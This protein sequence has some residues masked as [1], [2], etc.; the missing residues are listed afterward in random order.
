MDKDIKLNEAF[1]FIR[2]GA[3]IKQM[4]GAGGYPITRIE[5]IANGYVDSSR[6]GYADIQELEK[7]EDYI[8]K[9]GD[10]LMSHINSEKH[11][12][13]SA[14]YVD[15][16]N[17]VIHGMNLLGLRCK[18]DILLPKYAFYYFNSEL[19][20]RQIPRITKKSVNQASFSVTDLRQL[21]IF[22]LSIN[23]QQ[24]IATILDK[25]QSL[26][27]KRKEQIEACD[28]LVKS[29]FYEMFGDP[30]K[31]DKH[32]PKIKLQELGEWKSGGT[33]SRSNNNYYNGNIPWLSSGEL[34]SIYTQESNE[35]ITEDAVTNSSAK[36][37][38][39]GSLLLGMYDTA[40]LK[41]TINLVECT[42]NQAIVFAKLNDAKVSTVFIYYCI[43]IGKEFY[44]SQQRGVRQKNLN[45]S[46]VKNMEVLFPPLSLQNKFAAQVEKIEHQKN[47]L[48]QSL[49]E[50]ENNFNSLM[51]RAF[52]GE[53]F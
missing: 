44:K 18:K 26:I 50:L 6:M 21:T 30:V 33:P 34:N 38:P 3:S 39:V 43:Q 52:K 16:T 8:L 53:L 19:F 23:E 10:I 1:E 11:L 45:L 9:K 4:D 13:K 29:L 41:S 37:I 40:A 7:Y 12:G 32:L 35:Y 28:E 46:M 27:D 20:K 5:T 17:E 15:D 48:E 47:L 51:Q 2:N 31:N 49:K 42:C 14:L 22:T 24:K 36:L 25:A